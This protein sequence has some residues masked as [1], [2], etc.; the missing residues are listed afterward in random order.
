MIPRSKNKMQIL[1]GIP[2]IGLM[3][4]LNHIMRNNTRAWDLA[5]THM[6]RPGI[7][8]VGASGYKVD[9]PKIKNL[10]E[11]NSR[12][13]SANVSDNQHSELVVG[14]PTIQIGAASELNNYWYQIFSV[15]ENNRFHLSSAT[16]N[17]EFVRY[18]TYE[19]PG[20]KGSKEALLHRG[21]ITQKTHDEMANKHFQVLK[22]LPKKLH[23]DAYVKRSRGVV[24]L[25]GGIY[26]WLAYL[27]LLALRDTGSELPL[28]LVFPLFQEYEDDYDL[29]NNELPRLNAK[30]II[31]T[32]ILGSPVTKKW[33]F[34]GYQFKS[35]AIMTSSFQHVILLDSDNVLIQKPDA[36]FESDVYKR[37]GLITWPDYWARTISPFFYSIARIKVYENV[38]A[39]FNRLPMIT[40]LEITPAQQLEVPYHDLEGAVPNLSTESGQLIVNKGSHAHTLLVSLYYN[41]FGPEFFYRL[42]SLG[43]LGEGDKDTFVTAAVATKEPFYQ[44]KSHIH[45]LGYS[46]SSGYQGLGMGQV[47]PVEDYYKFRA[48]TRNLHNKYANRNP[49]MKEQETIL[50]N[51]LDKPFGSMNNAT[52]F[53][54]HANILKINP[55]AYMENARIFDAT[56]TRLKQRLYSKFSYKNAKDEVVDFELNRWKMIKRALCTNH[57][58]FAAFVNKNMEDVCLFINNNVEWMQRS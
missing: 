12:P 43:E 42:F 17:S 40:P 24:I 47:D 1:I 35:L 57:V 8:P 21:Y 32:D 18:R 56:K 3:L 5:W 44:V 49:K 51:E 55:F 15:F 16:G 6:N 19:G 20:T 36:I 9:I 11:G 29:C 41:V 7:G 14:Q 45:T 2:I 22:Q 27:S 58:Q 28:E 46:D 25:G 13:S 30:C 38:R 54:V 23:K 4:V 34:D 52:I 26:S 53:A 50:K 48:S 10:G 37:H 39:R 33:K 31:I